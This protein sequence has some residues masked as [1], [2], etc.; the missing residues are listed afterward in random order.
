MSSVKRNKVWIVR[1][2]PMVVNAGPIENTQC[3]YD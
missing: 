1:H 3:E 2:F